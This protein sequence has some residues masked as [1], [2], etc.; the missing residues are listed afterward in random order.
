MMMMMMMI[1]MM[2]NIKLLHFFCQ[3]Q[4][5]SHSFSVSPDLRYILLSHDTWDNSNN[6][7]D[8]A[9]NKVGGEKAF[10]VFN[11]SNR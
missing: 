2:M 9:E 3:R 6:R 5:N 8:M 1:M 10:S 7:L 11:V 4:L